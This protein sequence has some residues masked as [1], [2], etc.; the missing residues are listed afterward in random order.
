MPSN[1]NA[2]INK[3]SRYTFQWRNYIVYFAFVGVF[4]FFAVTLYD[5]GFLTSTNLLNIIRQTAMISIMAVAMTLVISAGEIDLSVGSIAAFS[6]LTTAL[7]VKFFGFVPS[8][9]IGMGTGAILGF[10]SGILVTRVMIPS[11]LVTLGMMGIAKGMAMWI[12]DTKPVPIVNKTYIN[13]F[14]YGSIGPI[15]I[16]FIWTILALII[17][18]LVLR[19]TKFGRQVL[20]TG[21]SELSARFSGVNTVRI[22]LMVLTI[23]GTAAAIAGMLYAGRMQSGRYSF[24]EGDELSVIA[25]VILGGTSLFGGVGTVVGAVIGSIMI[26]M[27]NNGLIIMGLDVSQQMIVKGII[28]ILAVALGKKKIAS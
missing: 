9:F 22:K 19:K 2:V 3:T 8:I 16:L 10:I 11:F 17:G 14:G 6:S 12:T 27:I 21:G 1:N 4:L 13:I 15:P 18:H 20:A 23:S 5:N 26:G 28:I 25:A 7:A 24:G